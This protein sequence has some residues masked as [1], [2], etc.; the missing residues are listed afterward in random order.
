[1]YWQHN[2]LFPIDNNNPFGIT[3]HY[4]YIEWMDGRIDGCTLNLSVMASL[5]SRIVNEIR[6]PREKSFLNRARETLIIAL[7]LFQCVLT[8]LKDVYHLIKWVSNFWKYFEDEVG[9]VKIR[10]NMGQL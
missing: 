4:I 7:P 5:V 1:M 10:A 8:L 3:S 2:K 9:P 6:R